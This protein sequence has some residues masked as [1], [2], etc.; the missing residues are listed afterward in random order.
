M[1]SCE[2]TSGM[3]MM[4]H[5]A[6]VYE[7]FMDL[8]NHVTKGTTLTLPWRLPEWATNPKL[9]DKLLD[10]NTVQEYQLFHDNGKPFCKVVDEDGKQHFPDHAATSEKIWR[11]IGGDEQVAKLIGMDMDIHLL[12]DEGIAE[13][14]S[15]QEAATLLLTGLAEIHSNANMFG[16][17]ESTS[18]KIKWKHIDKRGKKIVALL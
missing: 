12:K 18:F 9:W 15:R 16:G 2:Q 7:F 5:G 11:E 4:Q 14:A 1:L 10:D 13:F 6:S 8:K 3:N 17:I